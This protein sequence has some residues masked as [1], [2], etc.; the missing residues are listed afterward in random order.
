MAVILESYP[1]MSR[2]LLTKIGYMSSN[3]TFYYHSHGEK[4]KLVT[5]TADTS[6]SKTAVLQ[7]NDDTAQWHPEF[8]ELC[9][10]IT[11]T[12]NVPRFLFGEKGLAP[13]KDSKV[14]V[15]VIWMSPEASERGVF[16]IAELTS[17][18]SPGYQI[19]GKIVFPEQR[20]RGTLILQ[21]VLYLIDKGTPVGVE[22]YFASRKGT[23][24]GVLDETK[25]IIDGNGSLF[26]IH[27][28]SVP[29]N[30]LWWVQCNWSDP[31]E[32]Q[33]TDDNFCVFLNTAHKD[34]AALNINEGVKNSPLLFDII[35]SA[36]EVL[37]MKVMRDPTA[38]S[39]TI[40]GEGLAPGSISSVINYLIRKFEWH[41]DPDSPEQLS[42]DIRKTLTGTML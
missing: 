41:C 15:A 17:E 3:Y 9:A 4:Q 14:G 35:C 31:T 30:P 8:Y 7:L 33:F 1:K 11:A 25:I 6:T 34:Y 20:L 40:K 23:I 10:D 29:T 38:S 39:Q 22:K 24:L 36:L 26:P 32:D 5:S 37:I 28:T 19:S 12:I 13:V 18:T 16:P 42:L 27:E 2:E 21:T